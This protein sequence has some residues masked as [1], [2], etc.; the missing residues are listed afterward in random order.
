M[1][2][3]RTAFRNMI[4]DQQ[5]TSFIS[6]SRLCCVPVLDKWISMKLAASQQ[7]KRA[8]VHN[9]CHSARLALSL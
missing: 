1:L 8:Y 3:R 6:A 7:I 9:I 2:L 5:L 4:D